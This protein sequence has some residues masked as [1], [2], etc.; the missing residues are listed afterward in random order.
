MSDNVKDLR[1]ATEGAENATQPENATGGVNVP[2]D[3]QNATQPATGGNVGVYSH[4]FRKPFE[5]EGKKYVTLDFHFENLTGR[6][7]ITIENEMQANNEYALD[8]LLSRSFQSKMASRAGGIG[9]D[10]LEAMPIQEFNRITNAA[11][12]FLIDSGY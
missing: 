6:D 9:S 1:P 8:P 12:N 7:V 4:K 5:F 2:E 10:A 3:K 11:R